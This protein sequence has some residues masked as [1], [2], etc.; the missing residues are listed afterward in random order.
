MIKPITPEEAR[1]GNHIPEFVI[2][3]FNE[4]IAEDF[5][6]SSARIDQEDVI[7]RILLY[8]RDNADAYPN[9]TRETIFQRGWLNVE[10]IYTRS[11]WDVEYEKPG[12]NESYAPRFIF[13]VSTG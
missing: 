2:Q 10:G 1:N 12:Y 9:V 3:A 11:G 13:S 6:C 4:L 5:I 8:A 7:E